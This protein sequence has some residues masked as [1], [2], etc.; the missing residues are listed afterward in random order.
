MLETYNHMPKILVEADR[1]SF[2]KTLKQFFDQ[3]H[4]QE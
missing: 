4:Q 2:S 1:D 3:K